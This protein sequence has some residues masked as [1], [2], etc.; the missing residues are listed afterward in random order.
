LFEFV[1]QLCDLVGRA[2]G[3]RKIKVDCQVN[4]SA[5]FAG[6]MFS[7]LG[8]NLV[9]TIGL[10]L[11]AGLNLRQLTGVLA[12][13]FGHFAQGT[14]MRVSY[15]VRSINGWFCAR[16]LPARCLGRK[17]R[18]DGAGV[19]QRRHRHRALGEQGNGVGHAGERSGC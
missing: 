2:R 17:S 13:E 8:H 16:R 19:G 4:A 14:A 6:G 7:L 9:L 1:D 3:P 15:I 5:G 12:H 10:P 18:I 11:A